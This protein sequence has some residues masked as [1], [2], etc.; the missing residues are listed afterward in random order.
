[1]LHVPAARPHSVLRLRSVIATLSTPVVAACAV[2]R[3]PPSCTCLQHRSR[4]CTDSH[5]LSSR[6]RIDFRQFVGDVEAKW[7][8]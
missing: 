5:N 3:A 4:P 8:A 6:L 7:Q 1:M 2:N